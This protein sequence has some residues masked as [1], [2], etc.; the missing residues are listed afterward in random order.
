MVSEEELKDMSPEQVA[1]MQKKDCIF[2]HIVE[3]KVQ[4]KKIFEDDYVVA[5]L[6]INPANPGHVL[7]IPKEHYSIMPLV[8]ENTLGHMFMVAKAISSAC[9]KALKVQGTNIF[10]ANG[11]I[12]GQKAPHFMIH[13]IP[14]KEKDGLDPIFNL[15]RKQ[16]NPADQEQV[17]V[18]LKT[19]INE[20]FGIKEEIDQKELAPGDVVPNPNINIGQ[21]I[22]SKDDNPTD[23][24]TVSNLL[25]SG[26]NNFQDD[27]A[28]ENV[29]EEP[30]EESEEP[31]KE[32][33]EDIDDLDNSEENKSK[34][35]FDF[36][37]DIPKGPTEENEEHRQDDAEE[38]NSEESEE[39]EKP[40]EPEESE[41]TKEDSEETDE[42]QKEDDSDESDEDES[43]ESEDNEEP[44]S[45]N[46]DDISKVLF[47]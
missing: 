21:N 27:D 28:D 36:G 45:T 8:P 2:C 37:L 15:Q 9:L 47:K 29:E 40:E 12:A 33:E 39:V 14:R 11:A 1:E 13:V 16:V 19:K 46:L 24:D 38:N 18:R 26:N 23:L 5:L 22:V 31:K 35:L 41:D 30:E 25:E 32:D 44:E 43:S 20:V 6:D 7:L 3:G 10:V 17:W 42:T 34:E 4:S